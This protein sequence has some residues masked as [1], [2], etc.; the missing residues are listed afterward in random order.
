MDDH[1]RNSKI[2]NARSK[3]IEALLIN[4][5]LKKAMKRRIK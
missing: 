5:E 3:I 4:I 1:S 2:L